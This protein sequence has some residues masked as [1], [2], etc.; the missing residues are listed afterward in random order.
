MAGPTEA[1]AAL[2]APGDTEQAEAA[3]PDGPPAIDAEAL[4]ELASIGCTREEAAAWFGVPLAELRRRLREPALKEAWA[5]GALR[6]RV[7]IRRSQFV[8]AERNATMAGLLGRVLLG[9]GTEA[10]QPAA[11]KVTLIVDTGIDRG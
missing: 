5:Q 11:R 9:Q 6:G 3:A 2:P 1:G 10:N 4:A 7:R 8:L